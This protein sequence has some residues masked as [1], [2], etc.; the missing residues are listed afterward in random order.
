MDP[1][2]DTF[3]EMCRSISIEK[4]EV[5]LG[6]NNIE[7]AAA[8]VEKNKVPKIV[9][10]ESMLLLLEKV[11]KG[12]FYVYSSYVSFFFAHELIHVK[13]EDPRKN[14][15]RTRL[16]ALAWFVVIH[17]TLLGIPI[18]LGRLM[19]NP[20]LTFLYL[21]VMIIILLFT[22]IVTDKRYWEQIAELRADK[23][24]LALSGL[25]KEMYVDLWE[26]QLDRLKKDK[27]T[28][29]MIDSKN[30]FYRYVKR[31]IGDFSHP[32]WECRVNNIMSGSDWG[33]KDYIVHAIRIR[34]WKFQRR[35]WNGI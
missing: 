3:N 7:N 24:G 20:V 8:Y 1:F 26:I 11:S 31:N 27:K 6:T 23:L 29:D 32:S 21:I 28:S 22:N 13:Y 16:A 5:E 30:I 9:I 25:S 2:K 10:E 35:G 12:D 4:L 34:G 18:L 33:I 17:S 15:N 14:K 19:T